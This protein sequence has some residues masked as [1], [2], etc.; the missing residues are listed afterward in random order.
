M[1]QRAKEARE[2]NKINSSK[3]LWLVIDAQSGHIV[4]IFQLQS[5]LSVCTVFGLCLVGNVWRACTVAD[6]LKTDLHGYRLSWFKAT[7]LK[8]KTYASYCVRTLLCTGVF[9]FLLIESCHSHNSK[10]FG[11]LFLYQN[12]LFL[13]H[14]KKLGYAVVGYFV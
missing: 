5:I 6:I 14:C 4:R 3:L 1:P 11:F 7:K 10:D 8:V 13:I 2:K 9:I 12:L